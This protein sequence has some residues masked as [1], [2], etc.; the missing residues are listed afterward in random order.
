L[1]AL[2]RPLLES[3][4]TDDAAVAAVWGTL[5]E[6]GSVVALRFVGREPVPVRLAGGEAGVDRFG[7]DEGYQDGTTVALPDEET[8]AGPG[9]TASVPL[10]PAAAVPEGG[11]TQVRLRFGLGAAGRDVQLVLVA[12]AGWSE[13]EDDDEDDD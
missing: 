11:T 6:A 3:L 9:W 13:E 4:K 7:A 10:G 5:D 1:V 8:T 2:V 12:G